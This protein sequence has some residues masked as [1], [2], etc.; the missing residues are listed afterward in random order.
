MI[1]ISL[2]GLIG[3]IVGTAIA[4]LAY[5]RLVALVEQALRM[6]GPRA[7]VEERRSLESEKAMLRRALLAIDIIVF[8]GV[9]YALGVRLWG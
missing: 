2:A 7:T 3:A 5:G 6:R 9:G 8:A 1:D 4:A